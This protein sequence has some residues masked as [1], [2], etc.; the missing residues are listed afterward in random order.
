MVRSLNRG[1]IF[2]AT[3][4]VIVAAAFFEPMKLLLRL[5]SGNEL[6]SHIFLIPLVSA[7]LIYS[8]R[9]SIFKGGAIE[10]GPGGAVI[11]AGILLL[12]LGSGREAQLGRND[13]LSLMVL[14]ALVCWVGGFLLFFGIGA[15]RAAAFP[16]AFLLFMIPVPGLI[17]ERFI[18]LLQYCSA[19]ISYL[20][21]KLTGVPLYREGFVFQLPGLSVEVAKQ[22][23]GI[24]SSLSLL[25][26]GIL[27]SHL[28]LRTWR[29]KLILLLAILPITIFKN[30]V[31]IVTLTLLG[32]YVDKRIL[33]SD[34]HRSGGIPFFVVALTMLG[35]VLWLLRR[36]EQ[37]GA[38]AL[39]VTP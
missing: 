15:V 22:C 24:R 36:G 33:A 20:L 35:V 23:G 25:I 28:F 10:F 9:G 27:A 1:A 29:S 34:L 6:Y 5:S 14:A 8:G 11:A 2:F 32:A 30:A 38:K 31:R 39:E 7:Y 21:L 3:Y 17:M 12:L 37:R 26:T 4:T 18:A 19:E 16:L 13:Y